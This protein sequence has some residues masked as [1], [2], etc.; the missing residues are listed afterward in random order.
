MNTGTAALGAVPLIIGHG[1]GSEMRAPLGVS[2]LGG[3]IVSQLLTLYTTPIVYLW[4]DAIGK[5]VRRMMLRIGKL[6]QHRAMPN[7]V[8]NQS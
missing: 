8:Q 4:M 5:W 2:V 1:Y 6:F 7:S 3:M